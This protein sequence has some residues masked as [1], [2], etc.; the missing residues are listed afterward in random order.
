MVFVPRPVPAVASEELFRFPWEAGRA[1][2]R[3]RLFL[4]KN[5]NVDPEL[6]EVVRAA[7]IEVL[8]GS[9]NTYPESASLY[10]KLANFEGVRPEQLCLAA[11]SDGAIRSVFEA[12][13]QPGEPVLRTNPTFAMYGVYAQIF[14]ATDI[15]VDYRRGSD[16]PILDTD[17]LIKLIG[18]KKPRLVCIPNPDSPTGTVIEHNILASVIDASREV[19]AVCLID[20]AYYPFYELTAVDMLSEFE[21]LIVVRSTGKAWGM[22]GFRI[23]YAIASPQIANLLHKVK[24]MYETGTVAMAVFEAMLSRSDEVNKSVL[25][26]KEGKELM[27]KSMER[28]NFQTVASHG[29][30]LHVNFGDEAERIHNSLSNHVYY[31][32][33][34]SHPSLMGFSRF[35]M[36]PPEIIQQLVDYIN[37]AAE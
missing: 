36:A 21:N 12:F 9:Q 29:N 31:R 14:G 30:F 3:K 25:R 2:D 35:S 13:I 10:E 8:A 4:D 27:L 5:E 20:E 24:G 19:N 6:A 37:A 16:G 23:G 18:E 32:Q 34:T 1:R 22:A 7:A 17:E 28:L 26:I 15:A 11:G 33:E